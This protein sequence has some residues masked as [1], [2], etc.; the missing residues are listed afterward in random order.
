MLILI[1]FHVFIFVPLSSLFLR[2]GRIKLISFL[3][4]LN[5]FFFSILSPSLS[6][7]GYCFG[8]SQEGLQDP[9]KKV[10]QTLSADGVRKQDKLPIVEEERSWSLISWMTW[11]SEFR[12]AFIS[13]VMY[14][15]KA[16]PFTLPW[17]I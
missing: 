5:E 16:L 12:K 11:N 9:A 4:F 14:G 1:C 7:I 17:V 15:W 13:I 10:C 8:K 2:G 3:Q 6:P